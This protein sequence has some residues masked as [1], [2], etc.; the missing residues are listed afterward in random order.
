MS[1]GMDPRLIAKYIMQY[2]SQQ[3]NL[4]RYQLEAKDVLRQLKY[5]LLGYE[6]DDNGDYYRDANKLQMIN[7]K[8][9]NA[10][11]SF[12]SPQIS[13]L[14]SLSNISDDDIRVRCREF[15]KELMF[16]LARHHDEFEIPSFQVMTM[17][18]NTCGNIFFTTMKKAEKGGERDTLRKSYNIVE[19]E[20]HIKQTVP[21]Q[22]N[23]FRLPFST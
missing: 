2:Q 13:R 19:S 4:L 11:I 23:A 20:E 22:P 1:E 18:I 7:Q 14:I 16:M 21:K 15:E 8:G 6:E 3:D 5:E 10:I 17:I 12:L 9:A